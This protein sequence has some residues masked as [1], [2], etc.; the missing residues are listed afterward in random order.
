MSALLCL[1]ASAP[2]QK[3]INSLLHKQLETLNFGGRSSCSNLQFTQRK[4][5]S[6]IYILFIYFESYKYSWG[7]F[8]QFWNESYCIPWLSSLHWWQAKV[9]LLVRVM[10]YIFVDWHPRARCKNGHNLFF[11]AG[12][13]LVH[14]VWEFW[15][16]ELPR[17]RLI[18][19]FGNRKYTA[20][21][22]KTW[23]LAF[24]WRGNGLV[25][26]VCEFGRH[27]MSGYKK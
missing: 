25:Q 14:R 11:H 2:R 10:G 12:S 19:Q 27:A 9:A 1:A 17:P 18:Q 21:S 3:E 24:S 20:T 6:R 5:L 26:R 4:M 8:M 7:L 22:V 23:S 15:R 13:S 16:V